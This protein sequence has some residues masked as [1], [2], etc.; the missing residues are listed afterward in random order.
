M[1]TR[2]QINRGFYGFESDD[3][4]FLKPS[5]TNPYEASSSKSGYSAHYDDDAGY[6]VAP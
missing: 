5:N 3:V 2:K 6:D 1:P 4:E